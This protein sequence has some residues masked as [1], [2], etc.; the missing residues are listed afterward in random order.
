[1]KTVSF[2]ESDMKFG[3]YPEDECFC[4]VG[5]AIA[6][7]TLHF[8]VPKLWERENGKTPLTKQ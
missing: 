8:I 6:L 1:M 7:P 2:E 5:F 4:M 3:P